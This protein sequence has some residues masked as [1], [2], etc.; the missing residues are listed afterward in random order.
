MKSFVIKVPDWGAVGGCADQKY[1][2]APDSFLLEPCGCSAKVG[3]V[4][5]SSRMDMTHGG[6]AL[7]PPQSWPNGSLSCDA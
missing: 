1:D 2:E 3:E 6:A 4:N 7:E 5:A